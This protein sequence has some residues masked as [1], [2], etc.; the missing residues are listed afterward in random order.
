MEPGRRQ[1]FN[2]AAFERSSLST[3]HFILQGHLVHTVLVSRLIILRRAL[4]SPLPDWTRILTAANDVLGKHAQ[5]VE[6]HQIHAAVISITC[7][8]ESFRR[9]LVAVA[10]RGLHSPDELKA[11]QVRLESLEKLYE[12][13]NLSKEC[14]GSWVGPHLRD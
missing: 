8:A 5:C 6:C 1:G 11:L 14:D 7:R 10:S 9:D 4:A 12:I 2:Y 3:K 13:E